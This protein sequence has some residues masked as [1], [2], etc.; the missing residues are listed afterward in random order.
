MTITLDANGAGKLAK[1][2][3]SAL[4]V[5]GLAKFFSPWPLYVIPCD[6]LHLGFAG[7]LLRNVC[8]D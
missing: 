8:S 7:L 5:V 4:I 2:A 1:L 3:G 6:G